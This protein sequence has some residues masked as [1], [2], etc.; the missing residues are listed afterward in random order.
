MANPDLHPRRPSGNVSLRLSAP[1]E[2]ICAGVTI[3][4]A[5]CR[6]GVNYRTARRWVRGRT[7]RYPSGKTHHYEPVITVKSVSSRRYFSQ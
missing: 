4:E 7:V 5:A 3:A 6:V 2:A 1:V